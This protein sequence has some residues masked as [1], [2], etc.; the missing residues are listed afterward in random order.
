[1]HL[2]FKCGLKL[3]TT[4]DINKNTACCWYNRRHL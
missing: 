2:F 3:F 1:M 4:Y